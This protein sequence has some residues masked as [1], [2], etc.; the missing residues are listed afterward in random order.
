MASDN[1]SDALQ[2][3]LERM[4]PATEEDPT[5]DIDDIDDFNRINVETF[6]AQQAGTPRALNTDFKLRFYGAGV[7][8][9][10][11][12]SDNF[13]QLL[14][15]LQKA[16]TAIG[17]ALHGVTTTARLG[18]NLINQTKL[19]VNPQFEP[20]SFIVHLSPARKGDSH[21]AQDKQPQA[22]LNEDEPL[23]DQA[24]SRLLDI[25]NQ[26]PEENKRILF[27]V[28]NELGPR[29][30]RDVNGFSQAVSKCNVNVDAV[31]YQP[32]KP[33]KQSSFTRER[34]DRIKTFIDTQE[35]S[36]PDIEFTSKTV[37]IHGYIKTMSTKDG[38]TIADHSGHEYNMNIEK[39]L[40]IKESSRFA[41]EVIP[42]VL[43]VIENTAFRSNGKDTHRYTITGI[44][45][46]DRY[47]PL[48][49]GPD[50]DLPD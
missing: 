36:K 27:D 15:T 34:A 6:M 7:N 35:F 50:F 45:K 25:M 48:D 11:L 2:W 22:L 43:T 38:W 13:A 26:D 30:R 8:G 24:I 46:D 5:A 9:Y 33:K 37:S 10:S 39:D 4:P 12:E 14:G 28:L 29:V 41:L 44:E 47:E 40:S 20:G 32:L 49:F 23:I 1:H 18:N 17:A 31:L 42:V 3:F 16:V 19:F 21:N